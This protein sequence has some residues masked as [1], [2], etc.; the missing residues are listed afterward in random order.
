MATHKCMIPYKHA[1]SGTALSW[2]DALNTSMRQFQHKFYNLFTC[3]C[4]SFVSRCL[5]R[6]AYDG[7]LNWNVVNL[8]VLILWKGRWVDKMSVVRSFSPFLVVVCIG[9]FMAGWPFLVGMAIFSAVLLG[10]FVF[11]TYCVQGLIC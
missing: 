11:G 2:D 3:N 5:N 8:G 9:I 1:E 10:W 4:H 6:L 7:S